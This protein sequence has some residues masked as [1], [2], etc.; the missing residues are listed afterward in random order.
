[1]ASGE[2]GCL[3]VAG[4]PHPR[5]ARNNLYV[6]QLTVAARDVAFGDRLAGIIVEQKAYETPAPGQIFFSGP[7]AS[8]QEGVRHFGRDEIIEVDRPEGRVIWKV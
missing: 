5:P 3:L 8:N 2:L 6:E 7:D 4:S 1:M